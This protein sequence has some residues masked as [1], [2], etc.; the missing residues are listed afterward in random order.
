MPSRTTGGPLKRPLVEAALAM[1]AADPY[2]LRLREHRGHDLPGVW[3]VYDVN[4][5]ISIVFG[6]LGGS[7][8]GHL[9]LGESWTIKTPATTSPRCRR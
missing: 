3:Y 6:L 8:R 4:E 9:A 5:S 7:E 1:I 2:E